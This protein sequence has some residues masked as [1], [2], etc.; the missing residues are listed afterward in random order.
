MHFLHSGGEVKNFWWKWKLIDVFK[1][2]P[3]KKETFSV[4]LYPEPPRLSWMIAQS[5]WMSADPGLELGVY[6][7]DKP[8]TE[9]SFLP[10]PAMIAIGFSEMT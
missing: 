5:C 3:Q 2:L 6:L 8:A 7:C 10:G 1:N 9:G 4:F